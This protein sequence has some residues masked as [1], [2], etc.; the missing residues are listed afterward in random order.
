MMTG[1]G[2]IVSWKEGFLVHGGV[3]RPTSTSPKSALTHVVVT[4]DS[5]NASHVDDL[6]KGC[7]PV[8]LSHHAGCL[9][10]VYML[11]KLLMF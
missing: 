9:I 6:E 5:K 4:S 10:K 3:S 8:S 11:I 1:F 2:V 7:E